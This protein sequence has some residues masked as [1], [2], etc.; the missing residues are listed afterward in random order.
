MNRWAILGC[1]SG[2]NFSFDTSSSPEAEIYRKFLAVAAEDVWLKP[3]LFV[4][5]L[6]LKREAIHKVGI[7]DRTAKS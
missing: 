3:N 4:A 2:T 7:G 1:P 6:P 5:D